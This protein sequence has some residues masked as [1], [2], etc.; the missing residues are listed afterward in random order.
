M[1]IVK[2]TEL[3][4]SSSTVPEPDTG[5]PTLYN[6]STTYNTGD[7]VV[8]E[9]RIWECLADS[10][11]GVTP[12]S[13]PLIWYDNGSTN[14][15]AMFDNLVESQT[16]SSTDLEVVINASSMTDTLALFNLTGTQVRVQVTK[17]ASTVFDQTYD[18]QTRNVT[19]WS[20][21][22][23]E[24]F[25]YKKE[26]YIPTYAY[27]NTTYT[28]TVTAGVDGAGIGNIVIGRA[29]QV[30][31]TLYGASPSIIDYSRKEIDDQG[32][33]Y[34]KQ[35]RYSK[36]ANLSVTLPTNQIDN[37]L[38]TLTPLRGTPVVWVGGDGI[39]FESL[40][41]YGFYREFNPVIEGYTQSEYSLEIEGL[42]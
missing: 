30:G 15:Y 21:Y 27:I 6:A 11:T 18:L 23:F 35:G 7:T 31:F 25:D 24:E 4:L 1:I 40:I 39:G 34:L 36:R 38:R 2:P 12:G 14:Q 8:Y 26:L 42:T 33:Y 41:I 29:K 9:H 19:S 5:E 32:R 37:T 22:F 13:D 17:D 20:D 16:Y 3:V 28:I 10:T